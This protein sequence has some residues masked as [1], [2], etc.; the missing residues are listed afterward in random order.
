MENGLARK[1]DIFL[2]AFSRRRRRRRPNGR[3]VGER[4]RAR[5]REGRARVRLRRRATPLVASRRV[6]RGDETR[7]DE[8]NRPTDRPTDRPAGREFVNWCW[9]RRRFEARVGDD[10]R[11]R[12]GCG[13]RTRSMKSSTARDRRRRVESGVGEARDADARGR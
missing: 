2:R 11:D 1:K 13:R 4:R 3:R 8:T 5:G 10:A 9:P 6:A 12:E 7:R